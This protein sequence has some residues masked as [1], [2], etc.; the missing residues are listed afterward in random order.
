MFIL[1]YLYSCYCFLIASLIF[2]YCIK[3]GHLQ[4]ASGSLLPVVFVLNASFCSKM[5]WKSGRS[6][7]I[8]YSTHLGRIH[9]KK[10]LRKVIVQAAVQF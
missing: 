5:E 10:Q 3:V 8:I 1:H 6:I 7:Y 4:I 2:P 9:C